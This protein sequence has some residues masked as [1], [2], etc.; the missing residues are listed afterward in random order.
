VLL[1]L[2]LSFSRE[3]VQVAAGAKKQGSQALLL[4][5]WAWLLLAAP[6]AVPS[7]T[8]RLRSILEFAFM[9]ALQQCNMAKRAS[10]VQEHKHNLKI[11]LL[12]S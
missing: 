5:C 1:L 4:G 2:T 7:Y 9:V 11:D 10:I 12:I 3:R 6:T 8:L